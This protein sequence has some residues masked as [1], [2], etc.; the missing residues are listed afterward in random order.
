MPIATSLR[1][2]VPYLYAKTY[3]LTTL[4]SI[5]ASRPVTARLQDQYQYQQQLQH[6]RKVKD[7]QDGRAGNE[8]EREAMPW[9]YLRRLQV[10]RERLLRDAATFVGGDRAEK[11]NASSSKAIISQEQ[12]SA[13]AS[14]DRSSSS[15]P[16]DFSN[17]PA[18]RDWL[19]NEQVEDLDI[20]RRQ[21][22]EREEKLRKQTGPAATAASILQTIT[23]PRAAHAPP[24]SPASSTDTDLIEEQSP[25][26]VRPNE[27]QEGLLQRW[28]MRVRELARVRG[29]MKKDDG[30]TATYPELHWNAT[31]R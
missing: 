11:I 14:L 19:L 1:R 29:L 7:E 3:L 12:N 31:V 10:L 27:R 16:P 20:R 22:A 24:A 17:Y 2:S 15:R 30:D 4:V 23:T 21:E 6:R 28:K 26:W 8:R 18:Q 25:P 13:P 9:P 5:F